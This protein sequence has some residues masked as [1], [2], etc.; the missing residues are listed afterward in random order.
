M[1]FKFPSEKVKTLKY[2]TNQ[3]LLKPVDKD[4]LIEYIGSAGLTYNDDKHITGDVHVR[5]NGIPDK[6]HTSD[7]TA[8]LNVNV[9]SH[10]PLNIGCTYKFDPKGEMKIIAKTLDVNYGDKKATLAVDISYSGDLNSVTVDAKA[11]TPIVKYNNVELKIARKKEQDDKYKYDVLLTTDQNKYT[12]NSEF[13]LTPIARSINIIFTCPAGKTELL[14]KF[15]NLEDNVYTGTVLLLN[16]FI[17]IQDFF[18]MFFIICCILIQVKGRLI[19][20]GAPLG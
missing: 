11:T 8:K 10:P 18:Q 16:D 15:N 6:D 19:T 14:A 5:Q 1:D 20:N 7:G 12:L 2:T 13:Q 9:L 3:S 17:L 4:G